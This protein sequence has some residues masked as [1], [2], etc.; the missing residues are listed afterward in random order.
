MNTAAVFLSETRNRM[1]KQ[2]GLCYCYAQDLPGDS[3]DALF[4]SVYDRRGVVAL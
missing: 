4:W 3:T 1:D 2:R